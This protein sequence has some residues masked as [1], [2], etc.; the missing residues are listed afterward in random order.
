[1]IAEPQSLAHLIRSRKQS[2]ANYEKLDLP[3]VIRESDIETLNLSSEN[4]GDF[5]EIKGKFLAEGQQV[6]GVIVNLDQFTDLNQASQVFDGYRKQNIPI[7]LV[8]TQ[9]NLGHDPFIALSSG[10]ILENAGMVSHGAQR[11]RELGKGA[12]GGI[13]SG[14]LRTGTKVL[15]DPVSRSI[16]KVE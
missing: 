9:M 8:A 14:K 6:E 1:M 16:K 13:K 4:D 15:F 11:A 10:L 5:T 2:F 12:I 3:Q 7:I